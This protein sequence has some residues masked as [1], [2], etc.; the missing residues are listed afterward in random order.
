MYAT[1]AAS[2]VNDF[3]E[4]SMERIAPSRLRQAADYSYRAQ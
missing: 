3:F 4:R 1:L 2:F